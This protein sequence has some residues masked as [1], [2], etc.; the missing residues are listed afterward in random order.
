MLSTGYL[1]GRILIRD[2]F[3]PG[4]FACLRQ[5]CLITFFLAADGTNHD[6]ISVLAARRFYGLERSIKCVC[7]QDR[8]NFVLC[9][10]TLVAYA[11][12]TSCFSTGC[13]FINDPRTPDVMRSDYIFVALVLAATR[14]H[15]DTVAILRAGRIHFSD[16]TID[17]MS[18]FLDSL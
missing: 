5:N 18:K 12:L 9:L 3:S 13:I 10:F 15:Y 4:M 16:L 17:K 1:A 11:M 7:R 2:P 6:L 8:D 14:A